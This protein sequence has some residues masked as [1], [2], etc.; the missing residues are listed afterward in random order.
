MEI[1]SQIYFQIYQKIEE[2]VLEL[3]SAIHFVDENLDVYSIKIADLIVRISIEI[4]SL[5]KDIVTL[6]TKKEMSVGDSIKWLNKNWDL[7]KK[8]VI[9][10]SPYFYFGENIMN[11]QPFNYKNKDQNDYYST[12]NSIKHHRNECLHKATLYILIRAL[13]ALYV[14]NMNYKKDE[15]YLGDDIRGANMDKSGG[16]KIFNFYV[17]QNEYEAPLIKYSIEEEVCI[18][19][20]NKYEGDYAFAIEYRNKNGEVDWIKMQRGDKEFQDFIKER[21]ELELDPRATIFEMSSEL[22]LALPDII[23][24]FIRNLN[25]NEISKIKAIKDSPVYKA[26]VIGYK[27]NILN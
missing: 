5:A 2:E 21:M 1:R 4:E 18:Y 14:L 10:N 16:S 20:I 26:E 11:F 19:K 8:K 7:P 23:K 17:A 12:Y 3:S 24:S 15:I 22:G 6:E 9:I 25:A 13:G 27:E